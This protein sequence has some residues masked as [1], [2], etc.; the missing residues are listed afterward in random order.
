MGRNAKIFAAVMLVVGLALLSLAVSPVWAL[1]RLDTWATREYGIQVSARAE[2]MERHIGGARIE[3]K[4][5][6]H[7]DLGR[8]LRLFKRE[9][10]LYP[11]PLVDAAGMWGVVIVEE[12]RVGGVRRAGVPA[13][14]GRLY[15]EYV[16]PRAGRLYCRYISQVFHHEFFHLL[17]QRLGPRLLDEDGWAIWRLDSGY[18]D[19]GG[20]VAYEEANQNIRWVA[21]TPDLEGFLTLYSTL[22]PKEDRAEIF[23]YMMTEP[24]LLQERMEADE[25]VRR[26]VEALVAGLQAQVPGMD[27]EYWQRVAEG[28]MGQ[29]ERGWC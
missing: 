11:R 5:G 8:Y 28:R 7:A 18:P 2:D 20:E 17:S 23:S 10:S 12:L 3:G 29:Q 16:K 1:H 26:K 27:A 25:M 9:L 15:L 4:T 19:V 13:W 21:Y 24:A 6:N 22:S 14:E